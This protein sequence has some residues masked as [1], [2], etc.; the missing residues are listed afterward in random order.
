[1]CSIGVACDDQEHRVGAKPEP[2]RTRTY[3]ALIQLRRTL[4]ARLLAISRRSAMLTALARRRLYGASKIALRGIC[5]RILWIPNLCGLNIM[6]IVG[7]RALEK[8]VN[9]RLLTGAMTYR[10][11]ASSLVQQ[12]SAR[13]EWTSTNVNKESR[14]VLASTS[15]AISPSQPKKARSDRPKGS[16]EKDEYVTKPSSIK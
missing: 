3:T 16:G 12:L 4:C 14:T 11:N 2:K 7:Y 15:N 9:E 10:Y 6:M 5:W 13:K 1:M 8:R